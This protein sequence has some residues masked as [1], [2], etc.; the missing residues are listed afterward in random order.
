MR[1]GTRKP[2]PSPSPSPA[3]SAEESKPAGVSLCNGGPISAA[4]EGAVG[5]RDALECPPPPPTPPWAESLS[6]LSPLP[7]LPRPN[8][9][10]TLSNRCGPFC[11]RRVRGHSGRMKGAWQGRMGG[12]IEIT[13]QP[14]PAPVP[15][16]FVCN[17]CITSYRPY[18]ARHMHRSQWWKRV[19][20][21]T[22]VKW[23][24]GMPSR[25]SGSQSGRNRCKVRE[26]MDGFGGHVHVTYASVHTCAGACT[27]ICTAPSVALPPRAAGGPAWPCRHGV[28]LTAPLSRDS[29]QGK[30]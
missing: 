19:Y 9:I 20:V 5:A 27:R 26:H 8:G 16:S 13:A 7:Q 29:S 4:E 17:E 18:S 11:S 14:C 28:H 6:L 12:R 15:S 3:P 21:H 30:G 23:G 2:T 22:R 1:R 24:G 25:V 10:C